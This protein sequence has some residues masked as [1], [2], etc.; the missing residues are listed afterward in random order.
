MR[1]RAE[2]IA[3]CLRLS[4]VYEDY[5]FDDPNW[6]VMRHAGNKKSFAYIYERNGNIWINLKSEPLRADFWRDAYASVV[7]AYHMNKRHWISVIL[8]GSMAEEDILALI[9]DSYALTRGPIRRKCASPS[10]SF[11]SLPQCK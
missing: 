5:P 6:T 2:A 9:S 8:D 7:P 1:T 3:A 4:G 10:A 11:Y